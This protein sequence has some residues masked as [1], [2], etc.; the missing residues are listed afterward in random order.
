M[1]MLAKGKDKSLMRRLLPNFSIE[2]LPGIGE[3]FWKHLLDVGSSRRMWR[4]LA[5]CSHGRC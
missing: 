4:S 3:R 5:H 1:S 2:D